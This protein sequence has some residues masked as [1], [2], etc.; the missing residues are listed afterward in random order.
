[1]ACAV[2]PAVRP[3]LAQPRAA[4]GRD[5][6]GPRPHRERVCRELPSADLLPDPLQPVQRVPRGHQR[7]RAAQRPDRLPGDGEVWQSLYNFQRDA[8]VGIINK[9]ETYSGCILADSVGLG[10]TFT[11]LAVIKYYELRNKSVLVLTPKKLAENWTNYNAN[12][13]TNIFAR[14][15]G[16]TTTCSPTPTSRG[17]AVSRWASPRP[18]QLG[19]LRP[20]RDRRVPQLPQRRLRRREGVALP[21]AHAP[22]HPGRGEDQ[23]PDAVGHPGQQPLQRPEEPAAARLRGRVREPLASTSNISTSVEKVFRDAQKVFNEWS[24]LPRAAHHRPIL[25]MLDFDFFEL[26]DSV[27][28]ARSRKHIQAFYDTTEIGAFPERLPPRR[29]RM[30]LSTCRSAELQRDLRAAPGAHPRRLHAAG[31][32]LPE[33]PGEV[34][35]PLQ[36]Q[37]RNRAGQPRPVR[38]RAGH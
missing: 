19:Q 7:G 37:G 21:A 14:R 15:T 29:S 23:G 2:P 27:T 8:A 11:A 35:G 17:R 31:V 1:M 12:L 4:R 30:P 32:R 36:R 6:G 10:K 18:D 24:K 9:L 26:L 3:D 33:P 34:R 5:R 28:I 22:G 16:S 38:P 25:K 20:G 13:T